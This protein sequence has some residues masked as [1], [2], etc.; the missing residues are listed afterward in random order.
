MDKQELKKLKEYIDEHFPIKDLFKVKFFSPDTKRGDYEA[1]AKR[2]CEW[3]EFESI[4]EYSQDLPFI[5]ASSDTALYG[6]FPDKVEKDGKVVRGDG[7]HLS[8]AADEFTCPICTCE[9]SAYDH[10]AFNKSKNPIINIKCKGCKRKLEL[11]SCP[12]TGKLTVTEK[13]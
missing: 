9:Q 5:T 10:A 3:F 1:I 4:Y 7:F 12:M 6:K 11:F 13:V 8:I 2:I